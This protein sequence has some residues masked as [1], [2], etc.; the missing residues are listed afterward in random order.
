MKPLLRLRPGTWLVC[1]ACGKI[2]PKTGSQIECL[3]APEVDCYD[4]FLFCRTCWKAV[5]TM[6]ALAK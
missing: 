3:P 2:L 1:S 6:R 4:V 5:G